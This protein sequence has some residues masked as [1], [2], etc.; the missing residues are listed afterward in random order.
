M[1]VNAVQTEKT[2]AGDG[3]RNFEE[4]PDFVQSLA[5]GLSVLRAFDGDQ[6]RLSLAAVAA[7]SGLSRAAARRLVL[8]LQHL[9][10][11]RADGREFTLTPRVLELGFG[12]LGSLQLADVAQ[13]LMEDLS[14][15]VGESCSMAVLDGQSIVYVAR[16]PVRKVMTVSLGVGARLPAYCTSMGRALLSGLTDRELN[17][18][19]QDC[20]PTAHTVHTVI[21]PLRLGR[22]VEEVRALGHAYV[23]QEL[24]L[25]LCSV[26]VPV[27]NRDGRVAAALNVG[28]RFD[29]GARGRALDELVPALRDTA[30]ALERCIPPN[31][32][33]PV[34]GCK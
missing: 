2:S 28:M 4:G 22:L 1:I 13:P 21:D 14:H 7:R 24:E 29:N 34:S 32:L 31:W 12:F 6:P 9:G 27:H 25:G 19:L 20:R 11:V 3:I 30:E 26:A 5:R 16:I 10:Y 23:E 17:A 8:T 15:R 33:P 18:W